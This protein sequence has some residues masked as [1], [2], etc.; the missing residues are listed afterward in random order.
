MTDHN[1]DVEQPHSD[2]DAS[3]VDDNWQRSIDRFLQH[4]R[5]ERQLSGHTLSN[6]RRD[7]QKFAD[8]CRQR[9]IADH[10]S[11]HSADVRQWVAQLHRRGLAG[12]SLQRSLS[13]LRSFYKFFNRL[14]DKHNPAVGITAPRAPKRLP[15]AVDADR[16]QQYLDIE[17][18]DWLTLRDRAMLEL[19]YSS[20]LRL[21]ELVGLDK[22]DLDL[23]DALVTVHGKGSKTRTVPVG[24]YA[25]KALTQWL[26]C[27]DEVVSEGP[28]VF[29]SQRG[30]RISPRTVQQRLK[31]YSLQQGLGQSI[32]PH[33]LR[34]S[35]ASHLLESSGDL[36]A[37]QELLGHANISTTQV[38]THLDF[39][40]LA[41]VYDQTHPRALRK[42]DTPNKSGASGA[43]SGGKDE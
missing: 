25:L 6:Y 17:G 5:N 29:I 38:Y 24:R 43:P 31:K 9:D 37:V 36:R 3:T 13:A 20:G 21:S 41:K 15:K 26:Q 18:D 23:R 1:R 30:Q 16:L 32:H 35:F 8:Y 40:H 12:T 11:V 14:G 19:F 27:R 7:L 34:H 2:D 33:M 42:P 39:Q 10:H 4:L 22:H 28:A